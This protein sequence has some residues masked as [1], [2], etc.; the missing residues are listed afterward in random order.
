MKS[1]CLA[2]CFLLIAGAQALFGQLSGTGPL[3]RFHTDLGDIDVLLLQDIAPATVANFLGYVNP[4]IYDGSFIHRSVLNFVIQGG[5][6]KF[7]SGQITDL[8]SHG[9]VVN[10][11]HVSNTRGTLAMAKLSG[12]PNSATNQWF[13][14]ESD[15]NASGP[16]GLDTQ[17]GGFTVFGRI[18]TSSGLATMDAIAAVPR[19]NFGTGTAFDS[20]PLL[21]YTVGNNVKQANFVHLIWIKVL[22]QI[23]SVTHP[24]SN[25]IHVQAQGAAST[26][27]SLQSSASPVGSSFTTLTTVTTDGSGSVSY[28]D[29]NSGTKKFYRLAIPGT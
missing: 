25:T 21:N 7:V 12:D 10:E 28:N 5:G 4:S 9:S 14:N 16:N 24:A 3:V 20:V 29:T 18:T 17:N 27:Y 15:S 26:I 23:V 1:W 22:P 19:Y 8:P 2:V 11:F 13:F 6:Y